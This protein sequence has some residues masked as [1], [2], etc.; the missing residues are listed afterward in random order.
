MSDKRQ[1]EL[2][3]RW[4]YFKAFWHGFFHP[5]Q[6]EAQ[7]HAYAEKSVRKLE[8]WWNTRQTQGGE[9]DAKVS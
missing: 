6:T 9:H 4:D 2:R 1:L 7:R 8:Q 3:M 5:W